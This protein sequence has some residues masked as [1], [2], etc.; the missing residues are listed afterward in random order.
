MIKGLYVSA[1]IS[2]I[3]T[4]IVFT[5]GLPIRKFTDEDTLYLNVDDVIEWH[6]NESTYAAAD[7]GRTED[8]LWY[9]VAATEFKRLK[10]I[11]KR[12]HLKM[13]YQTDYFQ[14]SI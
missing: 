3:L 7:A 9:S 5:D 4:L 14:T 2:G 1:D 8:R 12:N 6:L 10:R 11:L 13:S